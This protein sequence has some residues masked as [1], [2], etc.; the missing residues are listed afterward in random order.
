MEK[1]NFRTM[2]VYGLSLQIFS[3]FLE[4][5]I[6]VSSILFDSWEAAEHLSAIFVVALAVSFLAM[7][8]DERRGGISYMIE[9]FLLFFIAIPAYYQISEKTFPWYAVLQP[10]FI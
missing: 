8:F 10:A 9:F 4:I 6:L 2:N 5:V 7:I 1:G 3:I